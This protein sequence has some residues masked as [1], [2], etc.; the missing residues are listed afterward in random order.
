MHGTRQR[1]HRE[2]GSRQY[3]M[4][5]G[6]T[7]PTGAVKC[8]THHLCSALDVLRQAQQQLCH[9]CG[10]GVQ[11]TSAPTTQ[12]QYPTRHTSSSSSLIFSSILLSKH[13]LLCPASCR[14]C[15]VLLRTAANHFLCCSDISYAAVA[16]LAARVRSA[17][18]SLLLLGGRDGML[19]SSKPVV[20]VTAVRTGCGKS[21]V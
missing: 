8:C 6:S 14:S 20:A 1:H 18:A 15:C 4:H 2:A 21:Q 19:A 17:G 3:D 7:S 12:H 16:A 9:H 13:Q 5:Q 11:Y 10:S